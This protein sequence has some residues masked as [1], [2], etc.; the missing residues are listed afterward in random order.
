M[1]RLHIFVQ[2]DSNFADTP[3]AFIP[4]AVPYQEHVTEESIGPAR[5]HFFFA[6]LR[7]TTSIIT[8][9]DRMM[10]VVKATQDKLETIQMVLDTEGLTEENREC[11]KGCL[12]REPD[13]NPK[14]G[15]YN[16][17]QHMYVRNN[18]K[19]FGSM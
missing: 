14:P 9:E 19:P 15:E 6:M 7:T 17:F 11:I 2:R 10:E 4:K 8:A 3:E 18:P 16:N 5:P 1:G 12:G 13:K